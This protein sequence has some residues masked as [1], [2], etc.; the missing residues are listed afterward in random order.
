MTCGVPQGS[1]LS[2]ILFN[3][4][5]QPLVESLASMQCQVYNYADDTQLILRLDHS[6][7]AREQACD[8]LRFVI[9]WMGHNA[10][11]LSC[12]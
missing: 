3:I 1:S 7:R 9:S 11:K 8:I 4:Y 2:P 5:I 12:C 10:L 6:V